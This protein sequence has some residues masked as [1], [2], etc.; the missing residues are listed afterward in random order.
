MQRIIND[1]FDLYLSLVAAI[2]DQVADAAAGST[3][4]NRFEIEAQLLRRLM[5]DLPRQIKAAEE[6][7][8]TTIED[9]LD[10]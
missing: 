3:G 6:A 8:R 7:A 9:G 2:V 1:P 5:Q 4:E 10:S